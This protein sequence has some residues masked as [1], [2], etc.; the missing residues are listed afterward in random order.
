MSASSQTKFWGSIL[1]AKIEAEKSF[2]EMLAFTIKDVYDAD[3]GL[4]L[5][6]EVVSIRKGIKFNR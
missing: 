5:I 6:D 1:E 2:F 4:K 3:E